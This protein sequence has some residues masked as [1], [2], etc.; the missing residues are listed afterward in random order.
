MAA[1]APVTVT[2]KSFDHRDVG[3]TAAQWSATDLIDS[4]PALDISGLRR[5]IVI[6][7]HPDDESL[8]A[9]GLV[10][11][12]ADAGVPV[13]VVVATTGEGSHPESPSMRPT[14]L[15]PIR[16]AEVRAA[17][18][19][20]APSAVVHQLDLGDGRLTA[21]VNELAGQIRSLLEEVGDNAAVSAPDPSDTRESGGVSDGGGIW[22]VAPWRHDRHP[23]HAA[24]AEAARQVAEATGARLLEFPLWAWHWAQPGDGTLEVDGLVALDLPDTAIRAKDLALAEHRSQTAPLSAAAGDEAV[25]SPTF[26]E[27]FRRRREL[28]FDAGS[29]SLDRG[30]FDDFY[31]AGSDPWGFEN[32]WYEKRKRALTVASLPRERFRSAFE[33][34]C[35]IGVLTAE[36]APRCD[37][38]LSTDISDIPLQQARR[39]L[40]GRPGVRFDQLRVPQQWPAGRFDLVVL[41]EIGYY[42]SPADLALLIAA[43]SS[44]LT[45]DG[46]LVACHWRHRVDDYPMTGDAVHKRIRRDSGLA[47]LSEHIEE[48]FRLDVLVRPP[49]V[50]VARRD[51]LLG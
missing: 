11:M 50:S 46:V 34:G 17:V 7:A 30:F 10:S 45:D 13:T 29:A 28:Y 39:R 38:L 22:L 23:D 24:A 47:L 12:A 31:S 40:A 20:L 49:V 32:R 44:S 18:G 36:L 3:T 48:D 2:G 26:T 33:P 41:S 27:H 35:A 25:V 14:D 19:R 8:G 6:A 9:G 43:A 15:A 42:C 1:A 16:R 37:Q 4:A 51:G 5:L 21:S